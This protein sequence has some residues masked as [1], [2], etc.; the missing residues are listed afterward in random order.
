MRDFPVLGKS[1]TNFKRFL[2]GERVGFERPPVF[3]DS[4]D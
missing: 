3:I 1:E 4:L 2:D